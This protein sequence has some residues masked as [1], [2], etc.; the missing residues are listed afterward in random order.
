MLNFLNTLFVKLIIYSGTDNS[1]NE[2]Y[3]LN[4]IKDVFNENRFD[5]IPPIDT[6]TDDESGN[7]ILIKLRYYIP[8]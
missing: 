3:S 1:E 7:Y 5:S 2:E 6:M 8:S 4:S